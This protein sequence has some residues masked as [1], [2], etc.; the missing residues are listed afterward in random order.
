MTLSDLA[1]RRKKAAALKVRSV[2]GGYAVS[3]STGEGGYVV[4][5]NDKGKL[6]CSCADYYLH[7]NDPEWVCKH[8][9]ATQ[10]FRETKEIKT[11]GSRFDVIEV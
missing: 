4:T 7:K 3:S 2:E 1:S 10:S 9:I 8:V 11:T 6:V 5:I